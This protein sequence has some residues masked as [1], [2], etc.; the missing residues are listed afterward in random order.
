MEKLWGS[1]GNIYHQED[2]VDELGASNLFE[3]GADAML[4]ALRDIGMVN[5]VVS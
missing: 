4:M 2:I 5:D 1:D 3:S